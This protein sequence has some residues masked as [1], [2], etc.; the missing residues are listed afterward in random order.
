MTIR[1]ARVTRAAA[2]GLRPGGRH[3]PAVVAVSLLLPWGA[4]AAPGSVPDAAAHPPRPKQSFAL[5][6]GIDNGHTAVR[7]GDRL[8]YVT[9][10][11]NTGQKETPDLLLS[12]T[13]VPGLE[14]ISSTPKGKVS[15][16]RITWKSALPTG[17]TDQFSVTVE[18]GRLSGQ[19]QRLAAVAC[20]ATLTGK[21]PIVCAAHSDRLQPPVKPGFTDRLTAL[22]SG[23][24]FW[25]G[26]TGAGS[27]IVAALVLMRRRRLRLGR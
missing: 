25:S 20:A 21:R 14:L 5:R 27:L 19:L 8:T 23:P 4:V 1:M 12:Q 9:K 7:Q 22:V 26:I 11:S 2:R 16:G 24:L 13:L 6:I 15:G 18:V 3:V 10:I 17:K